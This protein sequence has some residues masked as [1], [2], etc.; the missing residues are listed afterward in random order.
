MKGV[1]EVAAVGAACVACCA[2][3]VAAAAGVVVAPV[4]LAVAGVAAAGAGLVAVRQ[5][6]RQATDPEA[7]LITPRPPSEIHTGS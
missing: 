4:G 7:P 5:R 6:R 2:I 3:P 1:K